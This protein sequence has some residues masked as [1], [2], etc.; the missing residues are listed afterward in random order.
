[1]IR[2]AV[3]TVTLNVYHG[4]IYY[5]TWPPFFFLPELSYVMMQKYLIF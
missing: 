2:T 5:F 4:K 3:R 1:M